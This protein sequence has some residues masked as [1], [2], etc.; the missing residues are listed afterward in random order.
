MKLNPDQAHNN[1]VGGEKMRKR[2]FNKLMKDEKGQALVIVLIL[3]LV[4]GLIIA[5]MLSYIGSGTKVGKEVYE[6]RTD[7]FMPLTLALRMAYGR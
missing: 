6:K 5:P 1:Q 4:S 7:L 3:I 2:T